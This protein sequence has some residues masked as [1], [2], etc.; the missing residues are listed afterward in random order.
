MIE[1]NKTYKYL[2]LGFLSAPVYA[3]PTGVVCTFENFG[4]KP[5]DETF[6]PFQVTLSQSSRLPSVENTTKTAR[7]AAPEAKNSPGN[8]GAIEF[9]KYRIRMT[10]VE[11]GGINLRIADR[12]DWEFEAEIVPT[13]QLTLTL[14]DSTK[15][16][17]DCSATK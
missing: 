14:D 13:S 3:A 6:R 7:T 16:R 5:E 1:L 8:P 11:M 9:G 2:F 15:L 10:P 4:N 12:K 17:V